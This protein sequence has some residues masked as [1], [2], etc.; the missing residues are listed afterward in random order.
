MKIGANLSADGEERTLPSRVTRPGSGHS[1]T[2]S[3]SQVPVR[4]EKRSPPTSYGRR[5]AYE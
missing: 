3:H 2:V 5:C 4:P 1:L